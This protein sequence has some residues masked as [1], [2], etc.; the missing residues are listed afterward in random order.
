LGEE[1]EGIEDDVG[2]R[3][4]E[5]EAQAAGGKAADE[6]RHG[7]AGQPMEGL[8]VEGDDEVVD[9]LGQ[10]LVGKRRL[11]VDGGRIIAGALGEAGWAV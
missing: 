1:G 7:L 6:V 5:A 3:V 8:L 10:I 2:D 9:G 11:D 4:E